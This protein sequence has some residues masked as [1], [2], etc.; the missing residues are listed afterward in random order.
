MDGEG[1]K[2]FQLKFQ[3]TDNQNFTGFKK[4]VP[5]IKLR[6]STKDPSAIFFSALL[7]YT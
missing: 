3:L 5:F 1:I 4:F 7:R 2:W 6:V